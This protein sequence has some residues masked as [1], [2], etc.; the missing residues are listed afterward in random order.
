MTG[1]YVFDVNNE[2]FRSIYRDT[3]LR[4]DE[5]HFLF[6]DDPELLSVRCSMK[7]LPQ[8]DTTVSQS[9]PLESIT[10][11]PE[12]IIPAIQNNG[13]QQLQMKVQTPSSQT[14]EDM[15]MVVLLFHSNSQLHYFEKIKASSRN[16][17]IFP[18]LR[19]LFETHKSVCVTRK[20]IEMNTSYMIP[21][22]EIKQAF[23]QKF[24]EVYM[25]GIWIGLDS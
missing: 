18:Y 3:V 24:N 2:I 6:E 10:I 22:D 1:K 8:M 11:T 15:E 12:D 19:R 7:G 23:T 20:R 13:F 16:R 14:E 9:N 21:D 4:L 17:I 5:R 25:V